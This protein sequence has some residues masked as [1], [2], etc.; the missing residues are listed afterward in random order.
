MANRLTRFLDP[1][2]K[3]PKQEASAPQPPPEALP[4]VREIDPDQSRAEIQKVVGEVKRILTATEEVHYVALQNVTS[5][6]IKRDCA[7]VTTNRIILYRPG[8]FGTANFQDVLWQDVENV[9]MKQ[10]ML[11][12]VIVVTPVQGKDISV[13]SLNKRQAQRLYG[14]AQQY[15]QEWR[16][17]RRVREMEEARARAGGVYVT[18]GA[19]PAGPQNEAT[20]PADDLVARLAK[21]KALLDQGLIQEAE[22]ETLKAK[23]LSSL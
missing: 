9:A 8:I 13:G 14:L 10:G 20:P 11:S 15:E 1:E 4:P 18:P 22:Y 17:K 3:E 5:L 6:S 16:E 19:T 2:P 23:I 12:S 7:V 21:A